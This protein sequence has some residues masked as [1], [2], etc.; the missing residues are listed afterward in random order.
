MKDWSL[1]G[2]IIG[3]LIILGIGSWQQMYLTSLS[4]NMVKDVSDMEQIVYTGNSEASIKKLEKIYVK[5]KK[6][7]DTGILVCY[8]N[9]PHKVRAF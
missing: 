5:S 2:I 7:L 4:D 3:I 6:V 8:N 1:I 9:M